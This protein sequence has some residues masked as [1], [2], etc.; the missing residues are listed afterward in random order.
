MYI[1]GLILVELLWES[2]NWRELIVKRV[3]EIARNIIMSKDKKQ[4]WSLAV[5]EGHR[6]TVWIPSSN[7]YVR[8]WNFHC[9]F[10]HLIFAIRGPH[11][12]C[13]G[14]SSKPYQVLTRQHMKWL[15]TTC[16]IVMHRLFENKKLMVHILWKGH[17]KETTTKY[18]CKCVWASLVLKNEQE[19]RFEHQEHSTMHVGCHP[20]HQNISVPSAVLSN[21]HRE[22]E[23]KVNGAVC[24]PCLC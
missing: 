24:D 17:I 9:C 15:P 7:K 1:L 2:V 4:C 16:L 22:A 5:R 20:L 18:S 6:R 13:S 12:T 11:V 3:F 10:Q 21:C 8:S 23:C 14:G 19:F